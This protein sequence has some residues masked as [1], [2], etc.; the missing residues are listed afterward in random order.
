[1]R[2]QRQRPRLLSVAFGGFDEAA[3]IDH[4]RFIDLVNAEF[5]EALERIDAIYGRG[6]L[7]VEMGLFLRGTEAAMDAGKFWLAEKHFR[8]IERVWREAD[9]ELANAIEVSYLEDLAVGECTPV[10]YQAVKERMPKSL[11]AVLVGHH[12]NWK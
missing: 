6:L 11:R 7:H 10:R 2:C 12:P 5:P 4:K 8:F 3:V 9:P 1:V